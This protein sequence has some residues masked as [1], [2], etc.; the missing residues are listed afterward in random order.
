MNST[1]LVSIVIPV[2]NQLQFTQQCLASI[3]SNT[4][5]GSY[6]VIVVNDASTDGTEEFLQLWRGS[7]PWFH[8]ITNSENLGFARSCNQG[9]DWATS[10]Y[11]LFLNNDTAVT[12]GW[13]LPLVET[14]ENNLDIGI[15]A[16]KLV[17]PDGTIQHCGKVWGEWQLP[18]S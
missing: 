16:P 2:H 1:P 17:F 9:A 5:P 6:E 3:E 7:K 4:E 11:L 12:P 14:L 8:S 13:L 10:K 18:R 15:V